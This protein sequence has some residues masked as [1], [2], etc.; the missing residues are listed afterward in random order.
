MRVQL[1]QHDDAFLLVGVGA[2]NHG[3]RRLG[4]AQ[5]VGQVRRVGGN[6]DKVA[7]ARDHVVLERLAVIHAHLAAQHVKRRLVR[8]VLVG[9]GASARRDGQ[10]LHVDGRR[11]R[12]LGGNRSRVGEALLAD[13]RLARAQ[14]NA[15]DGTF[16]GHAIRHGSLSAGSTRA[17]RSAPAGLPRRSE[18]AARR[19]RPD[20]ARAISPAGGRPRANIRSPARRRA[21]AR[22][23]YRPRPC[24]PN[25]CGSGPCPS[26][27]W[28]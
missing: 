16:G 24:R 12:G 21:F 8:L 26:C 17:R 9:L 18:P 11:A 4:L 3:C 13:E 1:G 28:S 5:V 2:R 25:P 14:A 6:V 23:R 10:K 7:G 27:R 22:P 20:P 19:E 15:G